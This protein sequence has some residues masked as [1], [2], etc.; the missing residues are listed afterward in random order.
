MIYNIIL[1]D[2]IISWYYD[3]IIIYD[4]TMLFDVIIL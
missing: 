4:I 3:I 2:I 1:Y